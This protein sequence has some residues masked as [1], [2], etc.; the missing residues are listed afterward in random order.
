LEELGADINAVDRK[1]LGWNAMMWAVWSRKNEI[2]KYL[3]SRNDQFI[4]AKDKRGNTAVLNASCYANLATIKLLEELGADL[5]QTGHNGRNVLM[6]AR[7]PDVIK[8]LHSKNDQ[9]IH[10][11]DLNGK[12]AF[13]LE[14][15]IYQL[16][17]KI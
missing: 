12:T 9:L 8:Y 15:P 17:L 16:I 11:K 7:R 13:L 3:H 14:C 10:A 4:H 2:I 5:N 6:S 1:L